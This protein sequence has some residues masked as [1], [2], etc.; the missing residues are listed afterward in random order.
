M[1]GC[2]HCAGETDDGEEPVDG[3]GSVDEAN[4]CLHA[5]D[6]AYNFSVWVKDPEEKGKRKE[7]K[8]FFRINIDSIDI[9]GYLI[10]EY[11]KRK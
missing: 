1:G 4:S 11:K 5:Y 9:F 7:K 6:G 10:E 2:G 3:S 8:I